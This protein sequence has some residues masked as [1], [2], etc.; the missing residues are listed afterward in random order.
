MLTQEFEQPYQV[1]N[2]EG[3]LT[4]QL[5][6]G[7]AA[8]RLIQWYRTKWLTRLLS[9]KL[10][11]LQRQG[12][13]TTWIPSNGQEAIA[14]GLA[15]PL[16]SQ[17]W[18]AASPREMGGYLLK[19]VTPAAIAYFCRGFPPP[20]GLAGPDVHCLPFTIVIGTQTLHSVGLAM[21]ARLKKEDTVVVGTCG[22]GASSEGDFSEALNFAGVFQAPLVMVVVNNG[23]AISVPSHKQFA[24]KHLAQRGIGYG[25]PARLVDGNDILA[26]YA[27]MREAV[28]RARSGG[29][30]TLVEAVTHRQA[31][32]STA[33]DPTRY[34]PPEDLRLWE[35]RDPLK[36]LRRFLFDG[37][38]LD[39]QGDISL[40]KEV[41]AYLTD[42]IQKALDYPAPAP[43]AFFD[44]VYAELTPRLARQ[45]ERVRQ[46]LEQGR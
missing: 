43:E 39:E 30:P 11:A 21:A 37:G 28:E 9:N 4:G 15:T 20:P 14:V 38:Y 46:E 7:L 22:D 24:A 2:P 33:D 17:D 41:E 3:Q 13:A 32:H 10:V 42:Q 36:R 31:A 34:C 27:V 12:R 18:L 19:G 25:L 29:G 16:L 35:T 6:E 23:W 44:N 26:V 8:D 40:L 1:L 45:R 5:P